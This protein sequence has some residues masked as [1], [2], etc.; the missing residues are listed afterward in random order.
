MA[1]PA[2]V[3]TDDDHRHGCAPPVQTGKAARDLLEH[4]HRFG[5]RRQ[6]SE[7]A[8]G[9][10]NHH[11]RMHAV[12]G[13]IADGDSAA[14]AAVGDMVVVVAADLGCRE[15]A[16]GDI[17][18]G[19]QRLVVRQHCQLQRSGLLELTGLAGIVGL[20][21]QAFGLLPSGTSFLLDSVSSQLVDLDEAM[22]ELAVGARCPTGNVERQRY[23]D[24]APAN[25]DE[26]PRWQGVEAEVVTKEVEKA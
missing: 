18:I 22:A 19:Q 7:Q 15:H 24:S 9:D 6:G 12:S 3:D 4:V 13:G 23:C 8:L 25:D 5:I 16:E 10:R 21:N 17:D 26:D 11:A 20:E 1:A 2:P 14:P